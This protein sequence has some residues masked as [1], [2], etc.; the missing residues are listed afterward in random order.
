MDRDEF[1]KK[2]EELRSKLD[3]SGEIDNDQ[4]TKKPEASLEDIK[5]EKKQ[6]LDFVESHA[7]LNVMTRAK[8]LGEINSIK[9]EWPNALKMLEE[10]RNYIGTLTAG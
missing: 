5:W 10:Y 3:S 1:M 6:L 2:I 8:L 7:G 4:A 9:P